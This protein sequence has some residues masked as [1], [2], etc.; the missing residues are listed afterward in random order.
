MA[1]IARH[2]LE[3]GDPAHVAARFLHLL[4]AAELEARAA[5]RR[6]VRHALT[7]VLLSLVLDVDAKLL[8]ELSLYGR[9]REQGA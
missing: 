2:G 8:V 4:D 7:L 6:L 1:E 3:P 9:A 5:P